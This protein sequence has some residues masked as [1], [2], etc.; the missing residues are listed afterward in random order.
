ME[1]VILIV[2]ADQVS[3]AELLDELHRYSRDYRLEL[4]ID[5]DDAIARIAAVRGSGG[6]VA[7]VVAELAASRSSDSVDVLARVRSGAPTARTVLLLAWGLRSDQMPTVSRGVALGVVDTV[8]TKP[9]GPRD[10]DF[11]TAI[12][13]DLGEWS[14]SA[15]PVVEAVKIVGGHDGRAQ[16]IHER[17]DRLGVPSGVHAPESPIA[18]AIAQELG[19]PN[20][21]PSSR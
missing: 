4:A 18:A 16:D 11:H 9:T 19:P 2:A 20:G 15:A 14:W 5:T 12:T 13:E 6:G 10:E 7:M 21:T 17:L 1:P 3:G 8:L